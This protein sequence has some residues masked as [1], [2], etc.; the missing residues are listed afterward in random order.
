MNRAIVGVCTLELHIEESFSLKDKR[1]VVKS[2]LTRL[3]NEHHLAAAEIGSLDNPQEA[4][5]AF[6]AVSNSSRQIDQALHAALRWIEQHYP[7]AE[8]TGE[9]IEIL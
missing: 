9:Q 2:L 7:Q 1:S 4:V 3:M 6:A 8:I 5:I